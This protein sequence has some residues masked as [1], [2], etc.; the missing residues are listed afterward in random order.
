MAYVYNL[1]QVANS[2]VHSVSKNYKYIFHNK[3]NKQ[4]K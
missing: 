2:Y 4:T 3:N 1:Q